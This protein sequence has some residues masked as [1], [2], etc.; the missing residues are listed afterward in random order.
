M[1]EH[2]YSVGSDENHIF[3]PD[4]SPVREIDAG[5]DR[6]NHS[7]LKESL[8]FTIDRRILMNGKADAVTR[9]VTKIFAISLVSNVISC[10]SVYLTYRDARPNLLD[11]LV[12]GF[13]DDLVDFPLFCGRAAAD[14]RSCLIGMVTLKS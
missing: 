7:F 4:A 14:D 1:S 12:V 13:L 8:V 2:L 9:S 11:S 5:F 10:R 6:K 3:D